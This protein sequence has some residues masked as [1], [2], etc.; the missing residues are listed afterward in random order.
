MAG[1]LR[2]LVALD[3]H[4]QVEPR[5]LAGD[6]IGVRAPRAAGVARQLVV[7]QVI[8]QEAVAEFGRGGVELPRAFA[9]ADRIPGPDRTG[10]GRRVRARLDADASTRRGD[11]DPVAVGDAGFARG[12]RVDVQ[13]VACRDLAQAAVLRA[14]GVVHEHRTL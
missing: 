14:P 8:E 9:L 13:R 2:E 1:R 4:A 6:G 5:G 3:A 12:V 10:R 7:D 11:P